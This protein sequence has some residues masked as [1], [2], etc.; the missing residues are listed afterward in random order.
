MK[1]DGSYSWLIGE[2][3]RKDI[4]WGTNL[5]GLFP[6]NSPQPPPKPSE[7]PSARPTPHT[8]GGSGTYRETQAD[9]ARRQAEFERRREAAAAA[10]K[11]RQEKIQAEINSE[12][13]AYLDR[14]GKSDPLTDKDRPYFPHYFR[15]LDA[16]N[17]E[18]REKFKAKEQLET[19]YAIGRF[20]ASPRKGIKN[21]KDS[22]FSQKRA[23]NN[24]QKQPQEDPTVK[25]EQDVER[26]KLVARLRKDASNLPKESER[27]EFPHYFKERDDAIKLHKELDA[28]QAKMDAIGGATLIGVVAFTGF[29]IVRSVMGS[30][31]STDAAPAATAPVVKTATAKVNADA[32]NLRECAKVECKSIAVMPRGTD[33]KVINQGTGN[34]S[35]VEYT[36][37]AGKELHGFANK[38]ML[39]IKPAASESTAPAAPKT[40]YVTPARNDYYGR[41]ALRVNGVDVSPKG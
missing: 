25:A 38:S 2:I 31:D 4:M 33:V 3:A 6:R 17:A 14:M 18:L 19:L 12:R 24:G 41:V 11:K 34:W 9:I 28:A 13:A 20:I 37:P 8:Y 21:L 1:D 15:N 36:T 32:L 29:M 10:E 22:L 39:N 16:Y 23:T 40:S 26:A 5:T 7:Q 35:E 30:S 27:A